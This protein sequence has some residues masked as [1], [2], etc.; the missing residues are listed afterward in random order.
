MSAETNETRPNWPDWDFENGCRKGGMR[1]AILDNEVIDLPRME[2]ELGML[3]AEG[4]DSAEMRIV[5]AGVRKMIADG[6]KCERRENVILALGLDTVSAAFWSANVPKRMYEDN[7]RAK[8]SLPPPPPPRMPKPDPDS[9]YRKRL[10]QTGLCADAVDRVL[11]EFAH[12]SRE[13]ALGPGGDPGDALLAHLSPPEIA[14]WKYFHATVKS[15]RMSRRYAQRAG[16]ALKAYLEWCT[17]GLQFRAAGSGV[18]QVTTMP[19]GRIVSLTPDAPIPADA[20]DS[21]LAVHE[22]EVLVQDGQRVTQGQLLVRLASTSQLGSARA[23][24]M[25]GL[26]GLKP[27]AQPEN[28]EPNA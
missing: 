18:V 16:D 23:L 25:L 1:L 20:D 27:P 15:S 2:V 26:A 11:V 6:C 9:P 8:P 5:Q 22:D 17:G 4:R 24:E 7:E 12:A 28:G 19:L 10:F 14:A 21:I 13:E 3:I